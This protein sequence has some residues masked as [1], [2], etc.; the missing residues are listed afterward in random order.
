M[1]VFPYSPPLKIS[2]I[3]PPL[4]VEC[5]LALQMSCCQL[6]HFCVVCLSLARLD[7]RVLT[8]FIGVSLGEIRVVL[9]EDTHD[10]LSQP[11]HTHTTKPE[12]RVRS[13]TMCKRVSTTMH[14]S[15][16]Y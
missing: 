7:C 3:N 2:Y 6:V 1:R 8:T 14:P 4:T 13:I 16:D 15:V 11:R 9:E 5:R 10:Y 12:Y